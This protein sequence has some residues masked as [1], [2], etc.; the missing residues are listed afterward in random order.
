MTEVTSEPALLVLLV[1][2]DVLGYGLVAAASTL[3]YTSRDFALH[4]ARWA[5]D[6]C[7]FMRVAPW[8]VL[9][10]TAIIIRHRLGFGAWKDGAA[11]V[12]PFGLC[13]YVCPILLGYAHRLVRRRDDCGFKQECYCSP[14]YTPVSGTR[15]DAEQNPRDSIYPGAFREARP[16]G[17]RRYE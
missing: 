5:A 7:Y 14:G 13:L 8:F 4:L 9:V 1:V 17:H 6:P 11:S 10:G 15:I 3:L 12:L 2:V 16:V